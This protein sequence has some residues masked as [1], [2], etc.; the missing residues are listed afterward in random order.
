MLSKNYRC[1]GAPFLKLLLGLTSCKKKCMFE[2]K[3]NMA[4]FS[5]GSNSNHGGGSR[6]R[7]LVSDKDVKGSK[8]AVAVVC[9]FLSAGLALLGY[10]WFAPSSKKDAQAEEASKPPQSEI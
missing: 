5:R 4:Y 2:L 3:T 8:L 6:V 10:L 1:P 9:I 7:G